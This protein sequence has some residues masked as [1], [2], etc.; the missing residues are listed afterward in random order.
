VSLTV[1]PHCG[2]PARPEALKR[3]AAANAA[4]EAARREAEARKE[5]KP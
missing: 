4:V 5:A 3:M 1:C 2:E